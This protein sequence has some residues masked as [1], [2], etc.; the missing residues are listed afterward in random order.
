M[1]SIKEQEASETAVV[2]ALP[3]SVKKNCL[4]G[5]SVTE[6]KHEEEVKCELSMCDN[7]Y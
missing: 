4:N 7:L 6:I 5:I 3:M 2:R 1:I